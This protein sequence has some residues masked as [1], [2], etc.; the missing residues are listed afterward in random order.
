MKKPFLRLFCFFSIKTLR[1][2]FYFNIITS[3]QSDSK[4]GF[5]YEKLNSN[6]ERRNQLLAYG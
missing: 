6:P 2:F 5:N 1:L 3:Y 4:K